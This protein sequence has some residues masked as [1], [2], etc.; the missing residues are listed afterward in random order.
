MT[1]ESATVL[2][3]AVPGADD[4][5]IQR[6]TFPAGLFGFPECRDFRLSATTRPGL[7]WLRSSEHEAL[8]FLLADPFLFFPEYT[9]DLSEGD[10]AGLASEDPSDLAVLAIV[11]LPRSA[12]EALT[13]NLQGPVIVNLARRIARQVVLQDS[14]FGLRCTFG[15]QAADAA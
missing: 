14:R 11:T 8:A 2:P 1:V 4:S 3:L 9:V 10:L 6:V 15:V 13:A 12:G 7:Y 5:L